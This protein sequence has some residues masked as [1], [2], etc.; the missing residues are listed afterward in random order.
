MS[1]ECIDEQ[2]QVEEVTSMKADDVVDYN[3]LERYH[4]YD[5]HRGERDE[6][7]VVVSG[8]TAE[9]V[10]TMV[11]SKTIATITQSTMYSLWRSHHLRNTSTAMGRK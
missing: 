4:A 8:N 7:P 9:Q 10:N 5:R 11:I 3:C 6:Q 2:L 1:D